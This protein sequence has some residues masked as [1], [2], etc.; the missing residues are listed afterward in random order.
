MSISY[1]PPT[2][3]QVTNKSLHTWQHLAGAAHS[4]ALAQVF[5]L[6]I[7]SGGIAI[8]D[9]QWFFAESSPAACPARKQQQTGGDL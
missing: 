2:A 4:G 7:K 8:L 5:D 9:I 1:L 6:L 3:I